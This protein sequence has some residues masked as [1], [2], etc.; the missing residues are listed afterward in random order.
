MKEKGEEMN[1]N[2]KIV[3]PC[4]GQETITDEDVKLNI[5]EVF[6]CVDGFLH[7]GAGDRCLSFMPRCTSLP[8]DQ[9]SKYLTLD[10]NQEVVVKEVPKYE[11]FPTCIEVVCS[12]KESAQSLLKVHVRMEEMKSILRFAG[13]RKVCTLRWADGTSYVDEHGSHVFFEQRCF[14]GVRLPQANP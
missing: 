4:S 7:N 5:G 3:C 13:C 9:F 14:L 11:I 8:T 1:G 2:D 6:H 10:S 12:S